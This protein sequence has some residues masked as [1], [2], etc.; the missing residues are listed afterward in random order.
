MCKTSFFS[1]LHHLRFLNILISLRNRK[2]EPSFHEKEPTHSFAGYRTTQLLTKFEESMVSRHYLLAVFHTPSSSVAASS[3]PGNTHVLGSFT[4][5]PTSR[6]TTP[7]GKFKDPLGARCKVDGKVKECQE[8]VKERSEKA[9]GTV[10]AKYREFI[11]TKSNRKLLSLSA[12]RWGQG[13][14]LQKVSRTAPS[15]Y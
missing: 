4:C 1:A 5:Q 6:L 8:L 7:T 10:A 15:H 11:P 3:T 9:Q 13:I 14:S 2:R 12:C